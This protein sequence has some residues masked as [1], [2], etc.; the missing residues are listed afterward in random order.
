[1]GNEKTRD[2]VAIV[3]MGAVGATTAY[4]LMNGGV[5]SELILVD[6]DTDKVTG[7]VMDLNHGSSFVPPVRIRAGGY[8]DCGEAR[9]VII[10]AGVRQKL[11]ESRTDLIGRNLEVVGEI[12]PN[13]TANNDKC[14]I[15]MVSN[16]VDAMTYAAL[17]KSGFPPG[18]VIGS[19]T[20]LDTSRFRYLLSE[21]CRVA[22]QN[23]HAYIIGE[24]GD[25]EVAAW[26]ATSVAGMPFEMFCQGCPCG[27][28]PVDKD[29]IFQS[30]KNAAYEI[31]EK[32]GATFYAIGLAVRRIVQAILRNE[33][34]ILSVSSLMEGQ[35]GVSDVC[36]SLPSVVNENGVE[37]VL[38]M[39]LSEDESSGFRAS[40]EALRGNL[41][42]VGL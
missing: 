1:M 23:V 14:I 36:V 33:N 19:G 15:L 22:T 17:K 16:P 31:I 8:E 38:E 30:V 7:E 4:A 6:R 12:I 39:P 32:K 29:A 10:T 35:Y 13:V 3:G 37:R 41:A 34:I 24:H 42:K 9:V 21:H 27:C 2:A 26:S 40:A 11:G 5:T 28:T 20:L 18:R 25:S